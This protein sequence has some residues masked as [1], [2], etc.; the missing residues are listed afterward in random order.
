ML[1]APPWKRSPK[2]G[3]DNGVLLH[4]EDGNER[5]QSY[6]VTGDWLVYPLSE[7]RGQQLSQGHTARP[8]F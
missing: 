6:K 2:K 1:A 4:K 8:I 5:G 3:G 7:Q